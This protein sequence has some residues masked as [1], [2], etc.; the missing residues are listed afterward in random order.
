MDFQCR[1]N[2]LLLEED[3]IFF[4]AR[5]GQRQADSYEGLMQLETLR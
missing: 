5:K 4:D 2:I 3:A 1:W